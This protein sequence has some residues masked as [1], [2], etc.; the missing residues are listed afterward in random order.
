[1]SAAACRAA[2]DAAFAEDP[3]V[4][5]ALGDPPRI[6]DAPVRH[7]A[8]PFAVWR[9]WETRPLGASA[10]VTVE[11]VATLEIVSRQTGAEEARA[12]VAA[13]AGRANGPRPTAT[14]VRLVLVVPV[15]SDVFR[16]IDGR[17]WLGV[18]RL[19]IIAETL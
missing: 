18:V 13:L 7:S 14:D 8:F 16:A 11:H 19:K 9:R 12:A 6:W 17:T 3:A 10:G 15:Y 2:L 1:M 4:R 5:A